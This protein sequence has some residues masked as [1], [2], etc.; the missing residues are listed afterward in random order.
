MYDLHNKILEWLP[1]VE[2]IG[3]LMDLQENKKLRPGHARIVNS[4]QC[5]YVRGL[6]NPP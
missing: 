6:S 1:S 2:T 3:D 4:D 5:V